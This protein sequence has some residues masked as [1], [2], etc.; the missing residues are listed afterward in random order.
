MNFVHESAVVDD[1]ATIG[2]G[3]KVWHF[4]HISKDAVIGENCTVGQNV[5]VGP[6]VR[7]GNNVRIQNN[8]SVY[9]GVTILDNVFCGPSVVFTNV[10][11]PRSEV[12]RKQEFL[13]TLICQ[14]ASLGANST[15]VCGNTINEYA[16][17][18]AGAVVTSDVPS[19]ATV[20]GVPAKFH[21]WISRRG[22]K[23][24]FKQGDTDT[25]NE[26]GEVYRIT[27]NTVSII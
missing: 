5:Y 14:G 21:G 26:S 22:L 19:Y 10:I 20:R 3:T 24:E 7:I 2:A 23:L 6:N 13:E 27:Q 8:V 15:I 16:F 4:S 9:T 12:E 11:N 25:C 1:G 18:A 17:V